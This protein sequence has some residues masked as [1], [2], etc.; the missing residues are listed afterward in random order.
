MKLFKIILIGFLFTA[1][2]CQEG[3]I[4]DITPKDPGPDEGAPEVTIEFPLEGTQ[5]QVPELVTSID[6]K[7]EVVDDIEISTVT[8]KFDNEQIANFTEFKDYRRYIGEVTYDNV[9]NGKHTVTVTAVDNS[10]KETSQT[11]NFEKT[12]PYTPKYDG[13]VLYMPFDGD[14]MELL[15][16]ANATEVGNPGF[17]GESV[18]GLDAYAGANNSYLTFP[19]DGF[20]STEFSA[21]FW[22][23]VNAMPDRA[24]VLVMGPPDPDNPDAMNNRKSG[25]RFFREN[26]GGM[27][28]FKLNAGNGTADSWFDGGDAADVDPSKNE[29]VHLAFTI[30]STNA[31]VYIDGQIVTQG[32]FDGIDW[33][34]CDILSIMSGA[35]RFSGWNHHSDES[36]MDEL[37]L[38]NKALSITEIQKIISDES[39]GPGGYSS[40]YDG[41]VFYV[42]FEDE[43]KDMISGTDATVVGTPGFEAGKVGQAYAGAADS[44]IT[45]PTDGLKND[46]FSAVFWMKVNNDPDRG[47]ILVMGPEDVDNANYPDVQNLRTSGF[48]FFREDAAGM[49]RVKL[50]AGN[51]AADTWVDGGDAAD[52]D[53]SA[54][55]WVHYAFTINGTE[56]KVYIDGAEVAQSDFDGIDWTGCDLLSV[57]SGAPRF[58]EWGHG[59]DQSLMDELRIFNKALTPTEIQQIITDES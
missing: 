9:T 4:D 22:M 46:M 53:P 25:F 19:T 13:E 56:C 54:G 38:F 37:R 1:I 5:I 47:G 15:S 45:F 28:R 55:A 10:S 35:P 12:P 20:Q 49:Q 52:I 33:S 48:R 27:Q 17:A 21:V 30:S 8:V 16:F 50:N 36:Y 14:Y 57:M 43:N 3:Y 58:T 59:P 40:K 29:W 44:Y 32:D 41:E 42:P 6:I 31:V 24:G 26:A 23:K 34:G 39:G 51:G 2:S 11:V 18:Q 7:F